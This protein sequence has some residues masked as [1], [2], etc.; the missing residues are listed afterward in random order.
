MK[1]FL[2]GMLC[3][4]LLTAMLISISPVFADDDSPRSYK[5]YLSQ[6]LYY[7]RKVDAHLQAIEDNTKA[8]KDKL[9]A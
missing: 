4:A 3:G 5:Q 2:I 8:V 9:H 1:H 6:M 7:M